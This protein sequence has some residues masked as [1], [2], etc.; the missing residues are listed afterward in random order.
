M[1]VIDITKK[2][3]GSPYEF[4]ANGTQPGEKMD[5]SLLIQLI[6]KE[7]GINISRTITEQYKEGKEINIKDI[8]PG[9][10]I[11]FDYGK[12]IEDVGLYI[13]NNKMIH[14]SSNEG[15][16]IEENISFNKNIKII[17]RFYKK[18]Q[19]ILQTRTP[20]KYIDESC[21]FLLCDYNGNGIMDL[22]CVKNGD[23]KTEVHILNGANN[24]KS[25]LLQSQ[26]IL[27]NYD[28]SWEFKIG[29]SEKGKPNI[30]CILKYKSHSNTTEIH[31][32]NGKNNYQSFLLQCF[33]NLYETDDNWNFEIGDYNENGIPNIYCIHKKNTQSKKTE[34]YILNGNDNYKSFSSNIITTLH[35]TDNNWEFLLRDYK[36]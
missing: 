13:G 12:G 29:K 25:F 19:L 18:G 8:I 35:E 3:L 20:L 1:S 30:Y 6:M 4:E 15:K 22:F 16:V 27:H 2:Y 14:A 10:C 36:T 23:K 9:D 11:Y 21:Q 28:E 7:F 31:I 33:T 24:Y 32:L 34:I 5:C 26:S 17:K